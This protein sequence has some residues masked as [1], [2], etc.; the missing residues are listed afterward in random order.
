MG[1]FLEDEGAQILELV[2]ADFLFFRKIL[3][4]V[5]SDAEEIFSSREV[6]SFL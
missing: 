6:F 4:V 5:R 3:K 1:I 2:I